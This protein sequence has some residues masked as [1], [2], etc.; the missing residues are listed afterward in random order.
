M[1]SPAATP[2]SLI[3]TEGLTVRYGR[4][5][6]LDG[7]SL[8]VPVGS[9]YALLGRNGAGKSSLV[10]CLLGEQRPQAGRALLLG[11]DVWKQRAS[12]LREVGVV[13]EEPDAPPAMTASQLARFCS[14]L[15]PRWDAAGVS[16]RLRR[17]GVPDDVPFG[18]LS[19]GQKGQVALALALAPSPRLLVLDDPTLGL[20]PLARRTFFDELIG[21][22]ADR[23]TTVF[24]TTHDLTAVEG[25]ADRIGILQGGRLLLD[26]RLEDLKRRFRRLSFPKTEAGVPAEVAALAPVAVAAR[27]WSVEAVVSDYDEARLTP[28]A[29]SRVEISSLTLEEIF[30][31]LVGEAQGGAA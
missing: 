22:L 5:T 14:R 6:A 20:D 10:R 17:F 8:S 13:P 16:E 7:V 26:D 28:E 11:K 30:L 15:Y 24:M 4:R 12:V 1:S 29:G 3:Q 18:R 9:V 21:D 27:G 25:I 19:K 31:A 23:G 2:D